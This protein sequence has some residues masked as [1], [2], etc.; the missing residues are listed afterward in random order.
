M[1]NKFLKKFIKSE[2]KYFFINYYV[3]NFDLTKKN[4]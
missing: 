4:D 2:M 1:K 3:L